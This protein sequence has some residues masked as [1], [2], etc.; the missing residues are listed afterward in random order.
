MKK[1]YGAGLGI[2]VLLLAA[3][4]FLHHGTM[5]SATPVSANG[6]LQVKGNKIVNAEGKPFVIKGVSTHGMAWYPQYIN[7]NAFSSLKKRGVNTIR[8]AMYTEEYNGY[9]TG[10]S[11]NRKVLES[12]IDKG[13]KEATALGM[14]VI[15]DWH[16]LS[17]G[18]PL[19]HKKEAQVFFKKTAKKYNKYTNILFEICN[20]PNGNDGNWKNI[21]KYASAVVKAIR[22]VNKKSV[23]IVGTPTW[24]QDV[25]VA[26]ADP[27]KGSNIAYA[28][29][30]Y[31]STHKQDLRNK[32]ETAVKKGLPVI[33][34]EFGLSEASG[35][36][37]VDLKEANKWNK[38]MN[39]YKLGRV[40]WSLSNK[41][42][43]SALLKPSCQKVGGWKDS[44]FSKA[45]KWLFG[46]CY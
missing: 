22:S 39:R 6:R 20:E 38:L 33:V 25:D 27:L 1:I 5:A 19:K 8:L 15:I 23:I 2:I 3:G 42:E 28:F 9:C 13:V 10:N 45:G 14:Y 16:I 11:E 36:G 29:H 12:L 31:A 18:N 44:D 24:C 4:C 46:T 17:D 35:N 32:L 21:K 30:F 26:A 41:D 34:S 40:A 43:S 7:K 37:I